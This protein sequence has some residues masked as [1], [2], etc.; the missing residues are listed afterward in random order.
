MK[1]C[2]GLICTEGEF[3][4]DQRALVHK[5]LRDMGMIKF[6]TKREA[7]QERIMEG[8]NLCINEIEKFNSQTINPVNILMDTVGNIVNDFVFGIKY[9]WN[10]DTWKYLKH[11]QDEGI[12]LIGVNAGANF[13][14]ILRYAFFYTTGLVVGLTNSNTFSFSE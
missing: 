10:S 13:L 9:D 11:L 14:P 3:W 8:I 1:I 2:S 6:G 7:M 4:K 12:K 5:F